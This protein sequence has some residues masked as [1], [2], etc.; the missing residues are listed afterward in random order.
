V[1]SDEYD[2]AL[3]ELAVAAVQEGTRAL[4]DGSPFGSLLLTETPAGRDAA[5]FDPARFDDPLEPAYRELLRRWDSDRNAV[6][7]ATY[8]ERRLRSPELAVRGEGRS[9]DGRWVLHLTQPYQH[10]ASSPEMTTLKLWLDERELQPKLFECGCAEERCST[11]V[12]LASEL[13]QVATLAHCCVL[14][15]GH[16]EPEDEI[17]RAGDGWLIVWSD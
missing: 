14:A 7:Y 2:E 4:A 12:S 6:A 15:P 5:R 16:Q 13:W 10:G 1:P 17:L 3:M 11:E 8:R 9:L